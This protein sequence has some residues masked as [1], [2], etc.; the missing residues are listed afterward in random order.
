VNTTGEPPAD[1]MLTPQ[2]AALPEVQ[3]VLTERLF[4]E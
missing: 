1:H 3:I 2:D 4:R